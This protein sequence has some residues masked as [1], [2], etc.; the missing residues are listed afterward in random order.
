MRLLLIISLFCSV[1]FSH[2]EDR[3]LVREMTDYYFQIRQKPGTEKLL[4]E[5]LQD[6]ECPDDTVYAMMFSPTVC[7]RCEAYISSF[8]K[9][10]KQVDNKKQTVLITVYKHKAAAEKYNRDN[11]LTADHY[12]Y[13]TDF[14]F[15]DIFSF[16]VHDLQ[17]S[18][19]LKLK[20]STGEMLIGG[21]PTEICTTFAKQLIAYD[22]KMECKT[23]DVDESSRNDFHIAATASKAKNSK[24]EYTEYKI[25][26]DI[27]PIS[28]I[29]GTPVF[30]NGDLIF[31]DNLANGFLHYKLGNGQF[32]T[33]ETV[34]P[35]SVEKR[36]F[37]EI[38]EKD[39][40][41]MEDDKQVYYIPL[42]PSMLDSDKIGLSYSLPHITIDTIS[43]P[44][45]RYLNYFNSPAMLIK[46]IKTGQREKMFAPDFALFVDS[47]FYKHFTFCR[48]KEYILYPCQD[49]T[50]PMQ[51]SREE[52]ENTVSKNPFDARYYDS[53]RPYFA[54]FSMKDGKMH[55][56]FGNLERCHRKSFTGYYYT[57]PIACAGRDDLFYT[58][59]RSGY[60]YA[61][62]DIHGEP[63]RK[64]TAFEID[65]AAFPKPD[66]TLFYSYDILKRYNAF[67]SR[68]IMDMKTDDRYIYCL[69][70]YSDPG[71]DNNLTE[72]SH[73]V[74]RIN[75]KNGKTK[76]THIP[77]YSD[78][79]A[80]AYGLRNDNGAIS[81]FAI[82]RKKDDTCSVRV[83]K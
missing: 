60:I 16:N 24:M 7:L 76:E 25:D 9:V 13:D 33:P 23:F 79:E 53:Q 75:R 72:C 12:I 44:G 63:Y 35:D 42:S 68:S 67:F 38:P 62:K 78:M 41:P 73:S 65:T 56:R 19:I 40:R 77:R 32:Y 81:P 1:H 20:R 31:N 45:V 29:Y 82:Y 39:Y 51:Y 22:G 50:W 69:I 59:G 17:G 14:R 2:A 55:H 11:L 15:K 10:L 66:T 49:M 21:N 5:F 83:F 43:T 28:S 34:K 48:F 4:K 64:Y 18:Y 54:A 57:S 27:Q 47:F 30:E 52:Y 46:D 3:D 6:I 8:Q 26:T 61:T 36:A 58:D 80:L 70:K 37:I 74:I 71:M